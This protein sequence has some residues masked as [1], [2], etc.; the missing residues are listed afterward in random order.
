M[1]LNASSDVSGRCSVTSAALISHT[2][3][4]AATAIVGRFAPGGM[5]SPPKGYPITR[6]LL[7]GAAP[8]EAVLRT[9]NAAHAQPVIFGRAARVAGDDH[10]IARLERVVRDAVQLAGRRPLNRP[11]LH[12]SILVRRF[13]VHE[14]MRVPKH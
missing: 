8:L 6:R 1:F 3:I 5:G 12:V 4:I 11:A 13:D 2:T 14:R 7:E 9:E 10:V